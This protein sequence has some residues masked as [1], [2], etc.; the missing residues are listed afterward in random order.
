MLQ[1]LHFEK[2]F[3]VQTDASLRGI[4]AVLIQTDDD[5][6]EH[7]VVYL[8]RKLRPREQRYSATEQERLAI[9]KTLLGPAGN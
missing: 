8:T 9:V 6:N 7:P 5:G 3:I 2:E 1:N 4:G